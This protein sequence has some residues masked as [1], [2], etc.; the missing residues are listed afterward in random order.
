VARAFANLTDAE[1]HLGMTLTRDQV[2][3]GF[4][5]LPPAERQEVAE[6]TLR[7][8]MDDAPADLEAA[9]V[10]ECRRRIGELER[11]EVQAIP[12]EQVMREAR[13]ALRQRRHD[14]L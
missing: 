1:Y 4:M 3:A 10:D 6:E 2:V 14:R 11:G 12:G 8:A 5:A 13:E 9:W 7:A